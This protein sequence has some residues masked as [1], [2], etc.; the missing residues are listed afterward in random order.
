MNRRPTL[1]SEQGI[2][3]TWACNLVGWFLRRKWDKFTIVSVR[4]ILAKCMHIFLITQLFHNEG[5]KKPRVGYFQEVGPWLPPTLDRTRSLNPPNTRNHHLLV[6][7]SLKRN[8]E[9]FSR[10]QAGCSI[11]HQTF[12]W[13]IIGTRKLQLAIRSYL[14][15][16]ISKNRFL[17]FLPIYY[18]YI[19]G[20]RSWVNQDS[21]LGKGFFI[22]QNSLIP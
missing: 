18:I 7:T 5:T 14:H 22:G 15:F 3:M 13:V 6:H 21:G 17:Y 16:A 11:L 10:S 12:L 9:G 19:Y 1:F 2:F 4:H 20:W 8:G